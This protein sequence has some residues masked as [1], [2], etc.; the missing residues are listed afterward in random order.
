MLILM[1]AWKFLWKTRTIM[2]LVIIIIIVIV[3]VVITFFFRTWKTGTER[4][5]QPERVCTG[6]RGDHPPPNYG[7]PITFKPQQPL[8]FV[9]QWFLATLVALHFTP[10]IMW[11][12]RSAGFWTSIVLRLASLLD[13]L[14]TILI[15]IL[16]LI[17]DHHTPILKTDTQVPASP[18]GAAIGPDGGHP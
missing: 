2:T 5:W 14:M 18:T 3:I 1:A 9:I 13:S 10:L 11:V 15:L 4:A 12:G 6:S 17:L 16:I 7:N 8:F